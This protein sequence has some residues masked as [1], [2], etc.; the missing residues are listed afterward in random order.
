MFL[1]LFFLTYSTGFATWD[2]P[3]LK[4]EDAEK[5]VKILNGFIMGAAALMWM[6]TSFI[7]LFLYPGWINWT[8]FG[9]DEYLKEI[10]ILISNVVYFIF[11]FILIAIAFMNIIG[12]WEWT[13]ELKQAMPKF[14][15][16]VLI[17]PFSWFF[18]Q[19]VLSV[20]SVLTVWVLTLPYDSFKD[21]ELFSQALEKQ[22][23]AEEKICKDIVIAF[24]G[25]FSNHD[26][27]DISTE[28]N[29]LDENIKCK[30]DG[31]LTIKEL[32]T[33]KD[34]NGNASGKAAGL[35]NSIFWVISIYS[36]GILRIHELDTISSSQIQNMR[37]IA[38]LVFKIVFDLLFI[39]VYLL[40]MIA[41]LLALFVRWIRLWIFA[42][43]SPFFGLLYF[44]GKWSEWIGSDKNKFSIKE[45]ISLALVPVYVSAALAFGLVFILVAS[46]WLEREVLPEDETMQIGWFS[47]TLTG[48]HGDGEVEVSIIW[49]LIVEIFGVVILWIAVMA[50]LGASNTTKNIVEPIQQFWN[51]VWELAMKAPTYAPIIPNP[52]GWPNLS[53]ASLKT[54]WTQLTGAAESA[55]TKR[56][57]DFAKW[58]IGEGWTIDLSEKSINAMTAVNTRWLRDPETWDQ[59]KSALQQ[60]RSTSELAGSQ[61]FINLL[62]AALEKDGTEEW[63]QLAASL[64]LNDQNALVRAI[65]YLDGRADSDY[66]TFSWGSLIDSWT[67]HTWG[68]S[69]SQA[70]LDRILASWSLA[71][72]AWGDSVDTWTP[73]VSWATNITINTDL[74]WV[75]T[76]WWDVDT[77]VIDT[78]KTEIWESNLT[79]ANKA[80]IEEA[81][82]SRRWD[83]TSDQ[84]TKIITE[85]LK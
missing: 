36:Y 26:V 38:D 61:N 23:F 33:G 29:G 54:V 79:E 22:E 10:W 62:K 74:S 75:I 64:R 24:D 30:T 55:Q 1:S 19:L 63:K 42:M 71:T 57:S 45:F 44:F 5:V 7:T 21:K 28:E 4:P 43:L 67:R 53:A 25:D 17:V 72:S 35:Q 31:K 81:I 9:L 20:C 6:V 56:W 51:S 2:E 83:L 40:L 11:A 46:T 41:L 34:E 48:A 82:E 14:I 49:K 18:V 37:S 76:S 66:K 73:P 60:W 52:S 47:L 3:V 59:L 85:L 39:A 13:W 69:L 50:A 78:L 70:G 84:V 32:L 12:K 77:S 16:G 27:E 65:W 80:A 68:W 58:M 8:L 15:V